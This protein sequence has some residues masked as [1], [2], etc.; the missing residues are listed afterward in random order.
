MDRIKIQ[1]IADEVGVSN[2]VLIEKSKEL[3]YDVTESNSFISIVDAGVLVDYAISGRLPKD[4]KKKDNNNNRG[5]TQ[6][7]EE[8]T[9][10]MGEIEKKNQRLK[11]YHSKIIR[12]RDE[13]EKDK[14]DF[15]QY[16]KVE[17]HSLKKRLMKEEI[18]HKN[19]LEEE[20]IKTITQLQEDFFKKIFSSRQKIN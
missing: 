4:I 10:K 6:M 18:N 3:G 13:L 1:E 9:K 15:I 14:S 12:L 20:K 7:S 5:D 2:E 8:N 19:K 11:E 16:K 17:E